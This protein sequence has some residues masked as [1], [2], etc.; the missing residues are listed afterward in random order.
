HAYSFAIVPSTGSR[1]GHLIVYGA[2]ERYA[3]NGAGDLG[4]WLLQ[5]GTVGCS[6]T[7]GAVSFS[8][9]HMVG[10]VLLVGEF[11]VGGSVTTLNAYEW[12]GGTNPLMN[13]TM[14][15]AADCQ[16]APSTANFCSRSN[17]ASITTP[18]STQDKTSTANNLATAEFFEVG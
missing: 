10:D 9:G 3:N 2:F 12:V 15:G 8:G 17:T 18:W 7:K 5:D 16:T 14:T 4:Y 11:S 1:V 6:S 13:I